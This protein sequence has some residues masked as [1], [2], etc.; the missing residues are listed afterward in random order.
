MSS[1]ATKTTARCENLVISMPKKQPRPVMAGAFYFD[2]KSNPRASWFSRNKIIFSFLV[3]AISASGNTSSQTR[4]NFT[5]ALR[6]CV[7][8]DIF[9][10][11]FTAPSQP[12]AGI[13]PASTPCNH[14]RKNP[15]TQ[16]KRSFKCSTSC[17]F[18]CE[19]VSA[20]STL[21]IR[22]EMGSRTRMVLPFHSISTASVSTLAAVTPGMLRT[23]SMLVSSHR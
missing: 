19:T 15:H 1:S 3:W 5:A 4:L 11:R 13:C 2:S 10:S 21:H 22:S 17:R 7:D 9:N 8:F 16:K 23:I 14:S 18:C 12:L 6:P 20:S